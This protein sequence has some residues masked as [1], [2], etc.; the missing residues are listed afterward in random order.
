[1]FQLTFTFRKLNPDSE[2]AVSI[3]DIA[4]ALDME[5]SV[6]KDVVQVRVQVRMPN[7][8]KICVNTPVEVLGANLSHINFNLDQLRQHL[9]YHPQGQDAVQSLVWDRSGHAILDLFDPDPFTY[10]LHIGTTIRL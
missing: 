8:I 3:H 10:H 1:M 5:T 2:F 6:R 4:D 7:Q 9:I